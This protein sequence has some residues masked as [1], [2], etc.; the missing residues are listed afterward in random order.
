MRFSTQP[1][2]QIPE[3]S[4]KTD[5][6]TQQPELIPPTDD[7]RQRLLFQEPTLP[8]LEATTLLNSTGDEE[9]DK[10]IEIAGYAYDPI[11]D[12]FYS[13]L[14]PW[15]RNVGYCRLYDEAAAPLGMIIDC[16]PVYFNYDNR[17]WMI[18]FWKGQY[19]M[20]CGG[21]IGVYTSGIQ[22]NIPEIFSGTF[23]NCVNDSELLQMS[24][25]L[26]KN[27]QILF[28]RSDRHWWLTGFK[29]GEFAQ[30][31]ELTMD[32]EIIFPNK[33]MLNAFLD[34]FKKA[35]YADFEYSIN[36]NT[37]NFT[38]NTPRTPQPTTRTPQ[39]DRIIQEKNRFLCELYQ[40]ITRNGTTVPEKLKILNEEAP[41]LYEKALRIGSNQQFFQIFYVLIISA[42]YLLAAFSE[43]S[44]NDKMY[45]S[46]KKSEILNKLKQ[47]IEAL[48]IR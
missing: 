29:L 28:T 47:K 9:L 2:P 46:R 40:E 17:K 42:M 31:W 22:L 41:E 5:L 8:A 30:P 25:V 16:E 35:G 10:I 48:G 14:N 23:Y 19:D 3:N 45:L 34:G 13:I 33:A 21:E 12:I 26:K 24:Y 18:S 39:T 11:Q 44:P 20:V 6:L 36:G 32:V 15:Q 7:L 37:F 38:Y 43:G 27:G 1:I 4:Q